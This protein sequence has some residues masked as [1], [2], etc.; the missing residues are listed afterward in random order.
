MRTEIISKLF[1]RFIAARECFPTMFNV[2]EIISKLFQCNIAH[3]IGKHQGTLDVAPW[4]L[5]LDDLDDPCNFSG[6]ELG[7]FL[8]QG[9]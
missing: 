3:A 6:L 7:Q 2:A 5:T 8:V 9:H 4:P 1:Q